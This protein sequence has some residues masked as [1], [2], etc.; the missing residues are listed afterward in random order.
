VA[1]FNGTIGISQVKAQTAVTAGVTLLNTVSTDDPIAVDF[2][3][4]QKDIYHFTQLQHKK[5][6]RS[7]STFTLVFETDDRYPYPGEIYFL[8]RAVDAQTGTLKVRLQFPNKEN[9]L[10]AGMSCDVRVRNEITTPQICIPYK[11]V[12]EQLGDYFVYVVN[13]NKVSQQKIIPGAHI[14]TT[15][16]VKSGLKEQDRI[17]TEGV[18]KLH[19]GAAVQLGADSTKK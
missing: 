14:G 5:A 6:P 1:P 9:F 2:V 10:R 13:G 16:I 18:Q 19:E 8:D 12:T 11:A 17:V 4:D 3:I 7:D 15:L